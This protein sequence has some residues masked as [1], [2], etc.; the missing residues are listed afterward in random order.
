MEGDFLALGPFMLSTWASGI[1]KK[2]L[3][4]QNGVNPAPP[5]HPSNG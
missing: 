5:M 1:T 2:R 4:T 3:R